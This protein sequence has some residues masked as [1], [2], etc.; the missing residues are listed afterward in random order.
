MMLHSFADGR[1]WKAGNLTL[2]RLNCLKNVKMQV[3]HEAAN[4]G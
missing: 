3:A 1:F 2:E 4:V